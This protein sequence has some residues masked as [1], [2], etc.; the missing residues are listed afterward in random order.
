VYWKLAAHG[1]HVPVTGSGSEI[2]FGVRRLLRMLPFFLC[3]FLCVAF[4]ALVLFLVRVD[5]AISV[6]LD[7]E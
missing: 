3:T 4:V 7:D 5:Q 6:R 2:A 1:S